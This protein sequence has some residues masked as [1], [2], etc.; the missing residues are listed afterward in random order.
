MEVDTAIIS[1]GR[2]KDLIWELARFASKG[3]HTIPAWSGFNA[4]TSGK[5]VPVATIRY[6]PFIHAPPTDLSTIYTTLLKLVAVAEKLGQPHIL[7]TADLAIYLKAQQILWNKPESLAGKVT[8]RLGGMHLLM[9][10]I[11]SIGKLFGDGG[12]LQLLTATDVY[13]DATAR[14]MLQGKQLNRAVRGIKLVLEALSHVYLTSA[15]S[16]CHCQGIQWMALDTDQGITDLQHTFRAKD[17]DSSREIID[18][19][20]TSGVAEALRQFKAMGRSQ[21]ATFT[22]W[23]N[24]MDSAHIML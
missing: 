3:T 24:F 19:L 9:S 11:A 1:K 14:Q 17:K 20:D 2:D 23:D 7:V 4:M 12:L 22:F 8:M 13:A 18:K 5:T 21:S 15:Q 16:W 6:L 10:F